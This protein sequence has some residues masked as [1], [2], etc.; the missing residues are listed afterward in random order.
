MSKKLIPFCVADRPISLSI[1]KGVSLATGMKIGILSQA[2]TTSSV[3]K[4]LFASYPYD[5]DVIYSNGEPADEAIKR[6]TVKMADSGIFGKKGCHLTYEQLFSAYKEM[7][8]DYGIMID[9]FGDAEKTLE[10]AK[11][12]MKKYE[13]GRYRFDL[14]GVAQGLTVPEYLRCYEKLSK[15]GYTHIALG[16]LLRKRKN[17][18]RYAHVR[19]GSTLLEKLLKKV[20]EEFDPDW[21]FVLGAFHHKRIELFQEYGVWGSD[22]KG[23]IFNYLKRDEVLDLIRSKKLDGSCRVAFPD[24]KIRQVQG[25]SEQQ[26][27]FKLTRG[28]IEKR[29]LGAVHGGSKKEA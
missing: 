15:L 24:M 5:T 13:K 10:S 20:R 19:G 3:F 25:M 27:R 9:V 23:W 22:C 14:V 7:K 12:G 28:H 11:E 21:L 26:L 4:K 29:V 8:T 16:W 6:Q 17:T 2:A 18:V 1:I